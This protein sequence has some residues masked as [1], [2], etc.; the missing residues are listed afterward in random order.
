MS[1]LTCDVNKVSWGRWGESGWRRFT[2]VHKQPTV[3]L[4]GTYAAQMRRSNSERAIS[5]FLDCAFQSLL[6]FFQNEFV[7]SS[8]SG[9][10]RAIVRRRLNMTHDWQLSSIRTKVR[11]SWKAMRWWLIRALALEGFVGIDL[12]ITSVKD[13]FVIHV[14]ELLFVSWSHCFKAFLTPASSG[15]ILYPIDTIQAHIT[16][17]KARQC[18]IYASYGCFVELCC[19]CCRC[20][21]WGT[22]S[23]VDDGVKVQVIWIT[24]VSIDTTVASF[25]S[26]SMR[27]LVLI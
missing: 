12:Q 10:Y 17:N 16:R 3:A 6:F 9:S 21:W 1:G 4:Y 24:A 11:V 23:R 14:V 13:D 20:W 18:C 7:S 8:L 26:S 22:K 2:V 15:R 27:D 19:R 25:S 5:P